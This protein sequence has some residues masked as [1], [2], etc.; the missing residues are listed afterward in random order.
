[1][2]E[3]RTV[4]AVV[5]GSNPFIHPKTS[6]NINLLAV[7]ILIARNRWC[8]LLGAIPKLIG[9]LSGFNLLRVILFQRCA[10]LRPKKEQKAD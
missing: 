4:D 3:R 5:E 6:A 1:M 2:V 8:T 10:K 9:K 7:F